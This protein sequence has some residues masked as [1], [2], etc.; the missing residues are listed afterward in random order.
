MRHSADG[1]VPVV[2]R[3][4]A[5]LRREMQV[6]LDAVA[7][8]TKTK[9][10][11]RDAEMASP[12]R[13]PRRKR[14]DL[15]VMP[16]VITD[17][18]SRNTVAVP[19]DILLHQNGSII[20]DGD[21]NTVVMEEGTVLL[22]GRIHF[23]SRC[24]FTSGRNCRLASIDVYAV[25]NG[26]VRIGD[27]TGFTWH[28]R[29]QL[30][31]PGEILIGADCLIAGTTALS[32]SDMHSL[33]DVETGRRINPAKNIVLGA[34]VW[35]GEGVKVLKG[36]AIGDGTAV[37]ASA[38]VTKDIPGNVVAAGVPARVVRRGVTWRQE[39]L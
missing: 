15:S 34:R 16:I 36:V 3:A 11:W 5:R 26:N 20:F 22:G 4:F 38:V 28:T 39:L 17:H 7:V 27:R 32:V 9:R 1:H 6:S 37:G 30:H 21:D 18:G 35:L 24:T 2:P 31:E 23:G 10:L 33:V 29:L 8:R 19:E 12:S 13:W 14:L 25:K